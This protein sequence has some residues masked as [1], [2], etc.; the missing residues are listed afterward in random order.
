MFLNTIMYLNRQN[1]IILKLIELSNSYQS[2]TKLCY[3]IARF[4]LLHGMESDLAKK[5]I[6]SKVVS[7]IWKKILSGKNK[8]K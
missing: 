1:N 4:F 7:R 3:S 5:L 8:T 2:V 6:L